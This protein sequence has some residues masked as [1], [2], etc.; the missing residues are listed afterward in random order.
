MGRGRSTAHAQAPTSLHFPFN[1]VLIPPN[2]NTAPTAQ[3]LHPDVSGFA[4][5]GFLSLWATA[6]RSEEGSVHSEVPC[7]Q[8]ALAAP[9]RR[10]SG[11]HSLCGPLLPEHWD[12]PPRG[13]EAGFL[14]VGTSGAVGPAAF[15]GNPSV[16]L[17]RFFFPK[18]S[19]VLIWELKLVLM[20][21]SQFYLKN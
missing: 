7:R 11:S 5:G 18:N 9:A 12:C 17:L 16:R 3:D 19:R 15:G 14:P 8:S 2:S 6:S 1:H 20:C 10:A 4:C 13:R 21:S